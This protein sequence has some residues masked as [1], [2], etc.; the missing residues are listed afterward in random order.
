VVAA[1]L[2]ATVGAEETPQARF[3]AANAVARSGDTPKAIASWAAL[4]T[5][6]LESASLYW[7][8]A[9]AASARGGRGEALWALL[10]ARELD[11]TDRAVGREIERV[12]ESLALDAAEVAPDPRP[13]IVRWG[14]W[15]RLDL[16]AAALLATSLLA[17]G[18]GNVSRWR[19]RA[20]ASSWA[21]GIAGTLLVVS[22]WAA[23]TAGAQAVVIRKGAP[24][25]DGASPAAEAVGVLREGEV[26]PVLEASGE[27]LRVEDSSG[28]RGWAHVE[29]VRRLDQ[30]P[31]R[32]R[33]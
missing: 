33:S 2:V 29:D 17:R 27:F 3:A 18:L 25:L 21:A 14:R 20:R 12:R 19:R 11:P 30:A 1:G 28:A 31:S 15:L 5:S 10:R 22:L 32:P 7:N 13:F 6:G 9:Q 24:L 4:A 26:L 8:W 23:S 16:L